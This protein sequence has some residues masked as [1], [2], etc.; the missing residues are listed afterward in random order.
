MAVQNCPTSVRPLVGIWNAGPTAGVP[1]EE[2]VLSKIMTPT[3]SPGTIGVALLES[4]LILAR[5]ATQISLQTCAAWRANSKFV[6]P[7][8]VI[9][10]DMLPVRSTATIMFRARGFTVSA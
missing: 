4:A 9:C 6:G 2:P 3:L 10:D 8:G 7:P 5:K 1:Q